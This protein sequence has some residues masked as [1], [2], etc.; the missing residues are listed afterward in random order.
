MIIDIMKMEDVERVAELDKICFPTPWSIS[1]YMSEVYNPSGFYIVAR[2]NNEIVGFAGEWIVMDEAH[3]TTIG[4]APEFR[5]RKIG[6]RML[7]ALI[8]EALR[9]KASCILLEVRKH[10]HAA[11]SLYIKYGFE[12]L[13]IR[14]GYYTNNQ[15]DAIVMWLTDMKSEKFIELFTNNKDLLES[16]I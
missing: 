5:R 10:N 4:V 14:K 11:Q 7:A 9:R 15:E 12:A 2:E 8:D 6:E 1:A 3:I 16:D 13:A